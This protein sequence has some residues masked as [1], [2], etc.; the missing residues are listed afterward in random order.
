MEALNTI[1]VLS[2]YS[3]L[4]YMCDELEIKTANFTLL[5]NWKLTINDFTRLNEKKNNNNKTKKFRIESY[6]NFYKYRPIDLL[7]LTIK[8]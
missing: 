4:L 1:T 6:I 7:H 3:T 5:Y 2:E 8:Q